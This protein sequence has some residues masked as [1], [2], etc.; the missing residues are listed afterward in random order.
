MLTIKDRQI[1]MTLIELMVAILMGLI[2]TAA[3][4]SA[5][6]SYLNDTRDNLNLINLNQD[7]RAVMDVMVSDIRRSGFVTSDPET[8]FGCLQRNA[9][10]DIG[11]FQT[12]TATA[13]D[14]CIV[15]AYNQDDD[16]PINCTTDNP[17]DADENEDHFGFRV[18]NN[19]IQMK[20]GSG[21]EATCANGAWQSITDPAISYDATFTMTADEL[22]ITEMF[23]DADG[24]CN[25]G[26]PCV[27]CEDG[28][29]CLTVREVTITLTGTL[30]D[31]TSQ[32]ITEQVRVRNDLYEN[33]H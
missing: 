20:S 19:A 17:F 14:S 11:L 1:G 9:F 10:G 27:T 3:A 12:G 28:N 13:G 33:S 2:I 25:A 8:N 16:M 5:Y 18:N 4:I 23:A 7:M 32:T 21:S 6:I 29:Q 15:Y 26:E 24:V 22:D 31:G 30:N